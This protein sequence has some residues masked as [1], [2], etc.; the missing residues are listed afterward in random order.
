MTNVE[1]QAADALAGRVALRFCSAAVLKRA[2]QLEEQHAMP[3]LDMLRHLRHA[4]KRR[5]SAD[6]R[7]PRSR[8]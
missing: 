5:E 2:I 3:R 8:A 1:M 6:A 4:L 7:A